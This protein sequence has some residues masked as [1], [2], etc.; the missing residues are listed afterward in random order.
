MRKALHIVMI[1]LVCL[2]GL[3]Q[4]GAPAAA[5]THARAMDAVDTVAM[6]DCSACPD[7][8][9]DAGPMQDQSCPHA[10]MMVSAGLDHAP[11][12]SLSRADLSMTLR[13][14]ETP[15]PLA[16]EPQLDLPPPR[17]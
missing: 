8:H 14:A 4:L 11:E 5:M 2:I 15:A 12:F 1:A 10:Q 17:I 7:T 3:S 9:H 13:P 6:S 16:H